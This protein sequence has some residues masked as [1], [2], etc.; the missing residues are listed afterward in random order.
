[1]CGIAG[2]W[3]DPCDARL[4]ALADAL[5][6]RGPDGTGN[7]T[8]PPA[9][10]GLA[11]R[12]L[13]II[14]LEGGSQPLANED[15][16]VVTVFNGEIY[17]YRELQQELTAR[18]HRLR[19]QSDTEV[20]VHLYEDY[21]LDF[22]T[23]LRGMFALA[24][25]DE[26]KSQL[27]LARDRVGKKPLYY[28]EGPEEFLFASEIKGIVAGGGGVLDLDSQALADYLG[29]GVIH[30][31]AT[32]YRQVRSVLPA[33]I[34]VVQERRVVTRRPYWRLQMQP[35]VHVS[36]AEAVE[37][38][39][40]LLREAVKLRLR[41]DVPVGAF[42]SGGLD[43]GIITALAAE[44]H[45]APLTTV[46]IGFTEQ[47]FDERPLARQV[48]QRYGTDHHEVLVEPRVVEDLPRIASAYDQP[49][50]DSSAVP[51]FYVAQAT[52]PLVKVA[53]CGDGGDEILA[54]YR[55]YVAAWLSRFL[56]PVDGPFTRG[57]WRLLEK[58]LP[59]PKS[60]RSSYAFAHRLVRGLA[61]DWPLRYWAWSV[62]VFD[63]DEQ[64]VLTGT[65]ADG[66][67][68]GDWRAAV[69]PLPHLAQRY[70]GETAPGGP[71]DRM[72]GADF[73]GV[74]PHD[75]LV[76]M[77]IASMVH[78]LEVRAP[79]L[80]HVLVEEVARFPEAVKLS[81]SCTKPILRALSARYL[82]RTIQ[83]APK[84]GFEVPV[85]RWL[86]GPLRSLCE[87]VLLS[88]SGLVT[89]LLD[90]AALE[91]IIRGETPVEPG[92]WGRQLWSLMML[93]IWDLHVRPA[94]A[95]LC[96]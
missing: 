37:R 75:L 26:R 40:A 17:N 63:E 89:Q 11:H 46:T 77:D 21:G 18:D 31:P 16:T 47:Q 5:R 1:M 24:V 68:A 95:R 19:T 57:G 53:L 36:R 51:S 22:V 34:V 42:L 25:W 30:A 67:G 28:R 92:R 93:G 82:P 29:W 12:R 79:L 9:R 84:R 35:K 74:L 4:K 49:Y 39:D 13:A 76:K 52:R 50:G 90:R 44:E 69:D 59:I 7:W 88:R 61:L 8:T 14:D 71:L 32:I 96:P 23:K 56:A 45:A 55:R 3:G 6:H 48:A 78:G 87:D 70:L 27:V 43:S 33:E 62:D 66:A 72:L 38:V 91:H 41:A 20:I 73:L 86:R 10:L 81:S 54:G 15:G 2:I 65:A 64:R 60:Y 83:Q 58:V 80:D 94:A 85:A